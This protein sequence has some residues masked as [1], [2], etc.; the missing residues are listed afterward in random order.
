MNATIRGVI[1]DLD[2]TLFDRDRAII[3][4]LNRM[5]GKFDGLFRGIEPTMLVKV[6]IESDQ[7]AM[8]EFKAGATVKESRLKRNQLFLRT[9]G[10]DERYAAEIND[11]YVKTLP[12]MRTFLPGAR[13]TINKLVGLVK[14]GIITNGSPDVQ[15]RKLESLGIKHL[16]SCIVISEE[17]GIRKP[18]ARIF[19]RA[20][21]HL[22]E[23]QGGLLYVGDS[24]ENDVVGA[25]NAGCRAAWFNPHGNARPQHGTKPDYEIKRLRQVLEIIERQ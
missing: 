3:Q 2:D 5:A 18:D 24:Y 13:A 4:T 11:F 12:A 15:Y 21:A 16:L 10:R 20:A 6:F 9:L 19:L 8:E 22:D 14:V 1:F 23:E 25:K 7:K 17:I